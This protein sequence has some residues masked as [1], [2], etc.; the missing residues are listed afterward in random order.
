MFGGGGMVTTMRG[1]DDND[2][3]DISVAVAVAVMM[4]CGG[5]DIRDGGVGSSDKGMWW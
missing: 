3:D 4:L 2:G 1:S 5:G